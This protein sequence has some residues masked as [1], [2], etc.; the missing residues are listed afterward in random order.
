MESSN[1]LDKNRGLFIKMKELAL[2]QERLITEDQIDD[3]LTTSL[4]R[5]RLQRE[6]SH[7]NRKNNK[8]TL[9]AKDKRIRDVKHSLS[10]EIAEV[11]KSIQ[12]VDQK[13]EE[14]L[15]GRKRD[16]LIDIR[17]SRKGKNAIKGYSV[18]QSVD[19]RFIDRKG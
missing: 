8:N 6:I 15:Q 9:N 19:P 7:N 11:I 18:K 12:E 5:E 1:L 4:K 13:I 16:L 2:E 17:N 14:V 3:F 10:M